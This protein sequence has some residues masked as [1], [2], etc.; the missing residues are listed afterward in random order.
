MYDTTSVLQKHWASF[1]CDS[2]RQ[3]CE[4]GCGRSPA[5]ASWPQ[6]LG[7]A[8]DSISMALQ[9]GADAAA[10]AAVGG[11]AGVG[12]FSAAAGCGNGIGCIASV[13]EDGCTILC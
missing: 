1:K 4:P 9:K 12:C 7:P 8:N 13:D 5:A 11:S 10:A 6:R 3:H 2:V